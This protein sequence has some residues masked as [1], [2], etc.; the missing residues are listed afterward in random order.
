MSINSFIGIV[1][2]LSGLSAPAFADS[3][4]LVKAVRSPGLERRMQK[5][6]FTIERTGRMLLDIYDFRSHAR[7]LR[8]VGHLSPQIIAEILQ[9]ID[10]ISPSASLVDAQAG[11]GFCFDLP[12]YSVFVLTHNRELE[13]S[14]RARCHTWSLSTSQAKRV[15]DL[16][17]AFL[18]F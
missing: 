13:V 1:I 15:S 8:Q 17:E 6:I 11:R 18:R 9:E 7:E 4:I 16:A 12:S 10:S 2:L 14:R 3:D 5:K